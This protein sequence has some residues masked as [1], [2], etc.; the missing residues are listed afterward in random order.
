[1]KAERFVINE[2]AVLARPPP[3]DI[4][5]KVQL[6]KNSFVQQHKWL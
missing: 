1:M 4:N 2:R 6:K 5:L 3:G